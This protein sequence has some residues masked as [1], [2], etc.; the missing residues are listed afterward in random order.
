MLNA[1]F[2]F[3]LLHPRPL[4]G[5]PNDAEFFS[6]P[7]RGKSGENDTRAPPRPLEI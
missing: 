2:A 4:L 7:Y 3:D 1:I 5:L 6:T